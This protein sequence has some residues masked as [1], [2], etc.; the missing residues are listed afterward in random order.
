MG[1]GGIA[2]AMAL[3]SICTTGNG[4]FNANTGGS[5]LAMSAVRLNST[6]SRQD[7]FTPHDWSSLSGADLDLGGG[8]IMLIPGTQRLV[9]GG[10]PGRWHLINTAAMGGFNSSTDA[11]I[12]S[13][14]VTDTHRQPEPSPWRAV[15]LEQLDLYRRRKRSA[16][17]LSLERHDDRHDADE[18]L[19]L[20][21]GDE[22]HAGLAAFR[23]GEWHK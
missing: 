21:G 8:G 11:C 10:K 7:Y 6:W 17:S 23:L 3:R 14:M 5:D 12:Q 16:E 1:G 9:G 18:H 15:L 19:D 22:Q 4:N 2:W 13:F 20:R